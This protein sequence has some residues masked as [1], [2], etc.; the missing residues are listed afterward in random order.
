MRSM[1]GIIPTEAEKRDRKLLVG[2]YIIIIVSMAVQIFCITSWYTDPQHTE[3]Y[4]AV[5]VFASLTGAFGVLS[6]DSHKNK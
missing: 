3:A 1:K 5:F 4:C 6:Y 2:S